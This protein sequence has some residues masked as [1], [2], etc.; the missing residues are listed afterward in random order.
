MKS[1]KISDSNKKN[2]KINWYL[3]IAVAIIVGAIIGFIA[4]NSLSNRGLAAFSA[5]NAKELGEAELLTT[6]TPNYQSGIYNYP[7]ELRLEPIS[8]KTK[9]AITRYTLVNSEVEN[10]ESIKPDCKDSGSIYNNESISLSTEGKYFLST[11]T[12]QDGKPVSEVTTYVYSLEELSPSANSP[13]NPDEPTE[14]EVPVQLMIVLVLV[15]AVP[16]I[17]K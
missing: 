2:S 17:Q 12:C 15:L 13:I 8:D 6:S 9:G 4:T 7:L 16:Q 5:T 10:S 14:P 1:K 3:L 11:V